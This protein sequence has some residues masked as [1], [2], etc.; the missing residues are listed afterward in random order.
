MHF[1]GKQRDT[2]SNLD[3]FGA[4]YYASTLGQWMSPDFSQAP[5]ALP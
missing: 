4:R 3:D 5:A 1:T 2:E